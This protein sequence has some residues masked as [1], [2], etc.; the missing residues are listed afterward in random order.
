MDANRWHWTQID[1]RKLHHLIAGTLLVEGGKGADDYKKVKMDVDGWKWMKID[2]YELNLVPVAL[3]VEGGKGAND[4]EE[5]CAQ[6]G[7]QEV[8]GARRGTEGSEDFEKYGISKKYELFNNNNLAT[9]RH[10]V[11]KEEATAPP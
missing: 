7:E 2:A 4:G 5:H 10:G 3:L 8:K 11:T 6:S 1:A 9:K